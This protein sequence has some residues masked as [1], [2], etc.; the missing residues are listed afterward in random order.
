MITTLKPIAVSLLLIT[1]LPHLVQAKT[2]T[3]AG[4]GPT[5][6]R[7]KERAL[8][9][10]AA[11]VQV[12]V[13]SDSLSVCAKNKDKKARS[14]CSFEEEIR[15]SA[16]LPLLGVKYRD[17]PKLLGQEGKS[18]LLDSSQVLRLYRTVLGDLRGSISERNK[19]LKK[20]T[21]KD[22][23]YRMLHEQ[24]AELRQY[25]KHRLVA[26]LLSTETV[27][28]VPV[29]EAQL[30]KQIRDLEKSADSLP[31]A[32]RLLAKGINYRGIYVFPPRHRDA[33]EITPFAAA[34]SKALAAQLKTVAKPDKARYIMKGEYD[35]LENN[36]IR[37]SYE[38]MDKR[39]KILKTQ[40]ARLSHAAW[41]DFRAQPLAPDLDQLV[42]QRIAVSNAFRASLIT[43][44]GS[45]DLL[46]CQ[47]ET[48]RI[49]AKMNRTGYFYIVG[50]VVQDGKEFSYLLDLNDVD[51]PYRF[52]RYVPPEEVNHLIELGEFEVNAPFGI[53]HLQLF[54]ANEDQKDEIPDYRW[55]EKMNYYVI[56]D[57]LGNAKRG[58]SY[59]RGLQNVAHKKKKKERQA[60]EAKLSFTTMPDRGACQ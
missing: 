39:F 6:A 58:I 43:D 31:F 16:D 50:N 33:V 53:E 54:A 22:D 12:E 35:I 45:R 7:A 23:R 24:L 18:A 5:Q 10:L 17:L 26:T 51:G 28:E 47:G 59:V 3:G 1:L 2:L 36:D 8:S 13:K 52:M 25:R 41:K 37:I 34:L 38:V 4:Y 44:R 27:P 9:D 49:M 55:D 48:T 20:T 19:A 29:T 40:S 46:F 57:S 42:H 32:A 60:F 15:T 11:A 30:W 14:R 21:D 56:K